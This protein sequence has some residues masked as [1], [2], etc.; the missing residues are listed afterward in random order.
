MICQDNIKS[1]RDIVNNVNE[2]VF[3]GLELGGRLNSIIGTNIN[4]NS[5]HVADFSSVYI[6]NFSNKFFITLVRDNSHGKD[7]FFYQIDERLTKRI[8]WRRQIGVAHL[9]SD[10][11]IIIN[12]TDG[13]YGRLVYS[14]EINKLTLYR[15]RLTN[16]ARN[17]R[18]PFVQQADNVKFSSEK[19]RNKTIQSDLKDYENVKVYIK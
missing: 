17:N 9:V 12:E 18:H 10:N 4:E 1:L 7:A 3:E 11:E 13:G 6:E 15:T 14:P 19:I 16:N 8:E 2:I 5:P